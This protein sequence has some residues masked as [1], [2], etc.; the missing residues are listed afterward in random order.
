MTNL[1]LT[2]N[3][4]SNHFL[5]Y[6]AYLQIIG[7]ILVV[8][9]HS[10]YLHDDEHGWTMLSTRLLFSFRMPVFLF[11]SGFL[12]VY[13]TVTNNKFPS[14]L[15]FAYKKFKRLVI[16]FIFVSTVAF[17]PRAIM[18]SMATDP[19]DI[20][21]QSYFLGLIYTNKFPIPYF[22]FIYTSVTMLLVT[23]GG[24]CIAKRTNICS[25]PTMLILIMVI[26]ILVN[27]LCTPE[28][29]ENRLFAI[30]MTLQKGQ[31]FAMGAVFSYYN[32][33]IMQRCEKIL[34]SPIFFIS[35]A[36]CWFLIFIFTE[37]T[38][39][40]TIASVFGIIMCISFAKILVDRN[41]TILDHLKGA[42]Y[43]IFL[44]SW[45]FNVGTQQVLSHFTAFPWWV[46]SILSLLTGIYMPW[47]LYKYIKRNKTKPLSKALSFLL[48][49][50]TSV[51]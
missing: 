45:F 8:Y 22:W 39:F 27:C 48:G 41:I 31:Y 50:N 23:Y 2:N 11:V 30:R 6:I 42:T 35:T 47:L 32:D 15:Q 9:G 46:Y 14:W 38:L 18:S 16:P 28:L 5:Q 19:V 1:N 43:M 21:W 36:I 29:R 7:I 25:V 10:L 44:L 24:I 17:F 51:Q 12:L 33:Y 34:K 3:K 13:T 49:Q 4:P 37:Y 40:E 20:S 26:M